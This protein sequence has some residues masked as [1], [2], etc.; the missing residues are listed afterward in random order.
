MKLFENKKEI[1]IVLL[2]LLISGLS[3]SI[4]MFGFPYYE[5]DEGNYMAQAWSILHHGELAPYT[6]WYDHA[7]FGWILIAFWVKLT[8]GFFTFGPSVNSGRVLMLLLHLATTFFCIL[9]QNGYP[10]KRR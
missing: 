1:I 2:L 6:Y 5:N 8:G 4:N 7:P 3:H 9:L 10:E